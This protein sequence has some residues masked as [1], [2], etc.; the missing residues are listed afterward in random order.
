MVLFEIF[1]AEWFNPFNL[2]KRKVNS[3]TSIQHSRQLYFATFKS[4]HG[5]GGSARLSAGQ[6]VFPGGKTRLIIDKYASWLMYNAWTAAWQTSCCHRQCPSV[7]SRLS[8]IQCR[9]I[10][11]KHLLNR[12][13]NDTNNKSNTLLN[14]CPD[15]ED[16]KSVFK[17]AKLFSSPPPS[18][19]NH[20]N[21]ISDSALP[22][23]RSRFSL[24]PLFSIAWIAHL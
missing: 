1:R 11:M 12:W 24:V 15:V 2:L 21:L 10:Y 6:K 20:W 4:I 22:P 8:T 5:L 14:A 18:L 3:R 16:K 13:L 7:Q 23:L 17:A 19:S 9:S